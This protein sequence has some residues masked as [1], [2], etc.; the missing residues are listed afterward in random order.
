M[1]ELVQAAE[2]NRCFD[3][4]QLAEVLHQSAQELPIATGESE[5]GKSLTVLFANRDGSTW[6]LVVRS[7]RVAC[8]VT[9]GKNWQETPFRPKDQGT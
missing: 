4:V 5:D 7:G 2:P 1:I 6:T 3:P 9:T 8:I